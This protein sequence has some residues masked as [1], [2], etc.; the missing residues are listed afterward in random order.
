M[1]KRVRDMEHD[2]F[3]KNIPN[4]IKLTFYAFTLCVAKF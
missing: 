3:E 2:R 1:K 4:F